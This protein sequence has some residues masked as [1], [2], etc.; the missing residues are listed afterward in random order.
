MNLL[1]ACWMGPTK[2]RKYEPICGWMVRRTVISQSHQS[3]SLKLDIGARI[4]AGFIS[5]FPLCSFSVRIRSRRLQGAF[6]D[7]VKSQDA[8]PAQS[9]GGAHRGS[10]CARAFIG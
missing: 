5:G 6:G 10:V 2:K 8:M 7:L 3:L 9:L 4:I 1:L